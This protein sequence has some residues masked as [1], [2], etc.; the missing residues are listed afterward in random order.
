MIK[1]GDRVEL[2]DEEI[3]EAVPDWY[4]LVGTIGTVVQID[5]DYGLLLVE[6]PKGSTSE[7]DTWHIRQER[8]RR[9]E[10]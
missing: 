3:H 2:V 8:V 10:E 1:V 6:W 4:P 9:V 7:D 5:E